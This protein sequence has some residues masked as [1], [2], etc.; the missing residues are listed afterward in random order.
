MSGEN[1]KPGNIIYEPGSNKPLGGIYDP[2]K[3]EKHIPSGTLSGL[4]VRN[5]LTAIARYSELLGGLDKVVAFLDK[6][7]PRTMNQVQGGIAQEDLEAIRFA[8]P[9]ELTRLAE[10]RGRIYRGEQTFGQYYDLALKGEVAPRRRIKNDKYEDDTLREIDELSR[11]QG[12]IVA[13]HGGRKATRRRR[14]RVR[15]TRRKQ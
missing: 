2:D 6:Y 3:I 4:R 15:Q 9:Q 8:T 7:V 13:R 1:Y 10:L 11:L 14:H 5:R 12:A